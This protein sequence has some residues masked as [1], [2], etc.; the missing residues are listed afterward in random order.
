MEEVITGFVGLDAHAESTVIG[1]A[2]AGRAAPQFIGTVGAKA[3]Q[4]KG[5]LS[6]LGEPGSLLIVYEAGPGGEYQHDPSS[7]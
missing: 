7:L 6:K 4:I 5:A 2:E 1:L 3:A